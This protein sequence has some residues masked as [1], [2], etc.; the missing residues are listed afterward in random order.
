M[1]I[2]PGGRRFSRLWMLRIA[3]VSLAYYATAK[4]GLMFAVVAGTITLTWLPS[5]IALAA[6]LWSARGLWPAVL[7]GAFLANASTGLPSWV[8]FGIA[9]GNALEAAAGAFLLRRLFGFHTSL[10]NV[11]DVLALIGAATSSAVVSAS[12]GI[13]SLTLGGIIPWDDGPWAWMIWWM[14]DTTGMLIGTPAIFAWTTLPYFTLSAI[15]AIEVPVLLASLISAS[16]SIF[17]S[18][19]FG[20]F[21]HYPT[22]FALFPFVIWGALR[23]GVWGSVTVT[24]VI[25]LLSIIATTHGIGPFVVRSPEYSL[26]RWW[27]FITLVAIMG[28]LLGASRAEHRR[29][30]A[31]LK[32]A[33]EELEQRV[34]KRTRELIRINRTLRQEIA[35]RKSLEREVI[36]VSEDQQTRLGQE[37]HDGLGQHLT[38]VAFLGEALAEQLSNHLPTLRHSAQEIVRLVNDA[39]STTRSL[40][41]GLCPAILESGGLVAALQQLADET[42]QRCGIQ[43]IFDCKNSTHPADKIVVINLYRIAQE[44]T[45]NAIRHGKAK[46]I[47]IEF[48]TVDGKHHLLVSDDGVGFNPSAMTN[49]AGLGH[50]I[51]GYRARVIGAS[52]DIHSRPEEG[53]QVSVVCK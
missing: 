21:G 14:G 16:W 30:E 13:A 23:F 28:L 25:S 32:Q 9:T 1:K 45:N 4:L 34:E 31:A 35:M 24:L 20:G 11:R 36:Q 40:A 46:R 19:E 10:G 42:S 33:Q 5:G 48:A 12:V 2:L 53:T 6:M 15:S 51:M 52:L 17:D 18:S 50:H 3:L 26:I 43:C 8:A 38:G 22:A 44:A 47:S 37:L 29:A 49:P 41:R 39:I 7:A 27:I